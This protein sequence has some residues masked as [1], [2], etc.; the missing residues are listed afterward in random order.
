VLFGVFNALPINSLIAPILGPG[1]LEGHSYAGFP[2]STALVVI[3]VLVLTGALLNHIYGVKRTGKGI[4]AVDHIHYAPGLG[5][6]YSKA[7]KGWFDPYNIGIWSVNIFSFAAAFCDR[8]IDW[9]YNRLIVT[10]TYALSSGMR[11]LHT[12]SYKAYILWSL[13]AAA[14]ITIFLIRAL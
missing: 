2:R 3:T 6:I 14:L 5:W 1:R 7:E 11:R 8:A 13:G 4:G 10:V 9:I 12:G